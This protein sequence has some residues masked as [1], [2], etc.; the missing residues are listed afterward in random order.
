MTDWDTAAATSEVGCQAG[1]ATIMDELREA[2]AMVTEKTEE[3]EDLRRQ[4][5]ES[6]KEVK[7]LLVMASYLL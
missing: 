3:C 6:E 1:S 7:I 4:K 5:C 2:L